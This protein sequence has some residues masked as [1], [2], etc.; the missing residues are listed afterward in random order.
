MN[1]TLAPSSCAVRAAGAGAD[2]DEVE[3]MIGRVHV[4]A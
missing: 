4:L 1:A 3:V 2:D